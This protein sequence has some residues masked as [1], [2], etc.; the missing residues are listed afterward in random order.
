MMVMSA[1]LMI[2]DSMARP[3]MRLTPMPIRMEVGYRVSHGG[4]VYP[5]KTRRPMTTGTMSS[6]LP[7]GVLEDALI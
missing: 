6:S 1:L 4:F 7:C 5:V 2:C 3:A